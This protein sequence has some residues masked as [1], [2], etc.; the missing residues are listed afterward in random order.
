MGTTLGPKAISG[1]LGIRG[2]ES[3]FTPPVEILFH[4][5]LA[6]PSL[7]LKEIPTRHRIRMKYSRV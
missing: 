6:V 3:A 7:A 1:R 5:V 2:W 4:V